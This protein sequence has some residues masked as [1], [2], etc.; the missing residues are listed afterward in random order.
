MFAESKRFKAV[1]H[2]SAT[3]GMKSFVRKVYCVCPHGEAEL[4]WPA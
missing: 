3:P 1:R 4:G 2:G